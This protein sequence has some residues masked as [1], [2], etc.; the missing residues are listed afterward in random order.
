MTCQECLGRY[1]ELVD[2]GDG[3]DAVAW[4]AHLTRCTSCARYHRVVQRGLALV[5]DMPHP[6][7]ST[8]FHPRLQYRIYHAMEERDR[9]ARFA[10]TGAA[11]SLAI[12]AMIAMVAWGPLLMSVLHEQQRTAATQT[13]VDAAPA[14]E[15]ST[16]ERW[17][18]QA[19]AI[20]GGPDAPPT[21]SAA[22][23]GPYSPL[24]VEA[25]L[26]GESGRTARSV[27]AAYLT[28]VE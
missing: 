20:M 15:T 13:V 23:P 3:A 2:G 5:R 19:G 10:S 25:P 26:A 27:L 14:A 4:R 24:I 28:G 16:V 6:E 9:H 18:V 22:F 8:D 21:M 11:A 17:Y 1:S 12:A 7:P